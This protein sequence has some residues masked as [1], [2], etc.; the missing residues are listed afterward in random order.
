[1]PVTTTPVLSFGT[2]KAL[3]DA[4]PGVWL[5]GRYALSLDDS[6]FLIT[7]SVGGPAAEQLTIV[8]NWT[9]DLLK[10]GRK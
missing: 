7:R 8:Q 10:P 2:P 9:R 4:R 6:R 1:M 3:F 5:A